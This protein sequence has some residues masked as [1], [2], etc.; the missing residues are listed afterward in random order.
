MLVIALLVSHAAGSAGHRGELLNVMV[1]LLGVWVTFT[2]S[3]GSSKCSE[4]A[5]FE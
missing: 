4:P 2:Q 1:R 3:K 5:K